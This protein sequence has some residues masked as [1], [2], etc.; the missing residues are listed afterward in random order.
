MVAHDQCVVAAEIGEQPRLL[1]EVHHRAG[2]VVVAHPVVEHVRMLGDRQQSAGHGGHRRAGARV[3]V[4]D[5][6]RIRAGG[7][8]RGVDDIGGG[9]DAEAVVGLVH[10]GAVEVDLVQAGGGD[11]LVQHAERIE[12]DVLGLARHPRGDV[13]V[14]QVGHAVGV[15]RT[16]QRG[17]FDAHFPFGRG[18]LATLDHLRFD[19]VHVRHCCFSPLEARAPL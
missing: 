17:Q 5:D 8:H 12:Q 4:Q 7:V 14:D 2:E 1:G 9:V 6:V 16:V 3:G 19:A 18:Y 15:N 10:Q 13:V 11:F